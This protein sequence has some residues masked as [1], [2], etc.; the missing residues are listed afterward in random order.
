LTLL[1]FLFHQVFE[2]CHAAFQASR[3]K[4]GSKIGLWEKRRRF[5]DSFIFE[6]WEQ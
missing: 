3:V 4:A 2:L 5:I 6:T 1:A